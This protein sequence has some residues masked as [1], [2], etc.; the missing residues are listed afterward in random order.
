[1]YSITPAEESDAEAIASLDHM[2]QYDSRRAAFITRSIANRNC[3]VI[4][5]GRETIGYA[6]LEYSFYENG[7]ISMLCVRQEYRR[8]GVGEKLMQHLE[9]LCRTPKLFT[10]TNL[11]NTAMQ[12]LLAKLGY[13]RSGVVENLDE[14]D[15][16]LIYFKCPKQ[17]AV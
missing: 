5:V 11:S 1:M 8:R 13:A 2:A 4:S 17:Q 9:G 14:G 10:S 12:S 7:F 6:V 16:E 15:P 3:Y